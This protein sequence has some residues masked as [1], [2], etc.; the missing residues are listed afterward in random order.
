MSFHEPEVERTRKMRGVLVVELAELQGLKSRDLEEIKAWMTRTQ[1][2]WTPKWMEASRMFLR[3]FLMFGTTNADDFL[4]DP[5][6]ERRCLPIAV[7][8][9]FGFKSVDVDAII[10]VRDQLWAEGREMYAKHGVMWQDAERLA[11]GEHGNYKAEDTWRDA[12]SRW[13]DRGDMS[14]ETPRGKPFLSTLEVAEGALGLAPRLIKYADQRRI[15]K[16]LHDEGYV[17][18]VRRVGG[19]PTKV[20]GRD[21][22]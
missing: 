7:G 22:G 1:E 15:A 3:R 13:L 5:T 9:R 14:D 12:V 2:H 20:W 16:I 17:P 18:I 11:R 21:A 8:R 10:S 6:G 4:D 19:K